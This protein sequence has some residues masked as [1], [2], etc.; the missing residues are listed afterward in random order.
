M[1]RVCAVEGMMVISLYEGEIGIETQQ[2]TQPSTDSAKAT[3]KAARFCLL[4]ILVGSR[5]EPYLL[6]VVHP[7]LGASA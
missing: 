5:S 4:S 3:S 1:R 6:E 7:Q 2:G